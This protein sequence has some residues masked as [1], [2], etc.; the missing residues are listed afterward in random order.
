MALINPYELLEKLR[1]LAREHPKSSAIAFYRAT[2]MRSS[3]T[4]S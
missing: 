3:L 4:T 2:A 1:I